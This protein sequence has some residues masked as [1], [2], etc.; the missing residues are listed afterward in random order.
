M[1]FSR[2]S[3]PAFFC[4]AFV[5]ALMGTMEAMVRPF[6]DLVLGQMQ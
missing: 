4:F 2:L 3:Q 6:L 1:G 5:S